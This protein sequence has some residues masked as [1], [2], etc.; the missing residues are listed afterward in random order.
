MLGRVPIRDLRNVMAAIQDHPSED[1]AVGSAR[2]PAGKIEAVLAEFSRRHAGEENPRISLGEL[3][4][5]MQKRAFGLL[6]LML[7]LPCCLPF[8]YGLPQIVALPILLLAGQMALGR[9]TP[10]LPERLRKRSFT[11]SSISNALARSRRY[12]A[13]V[14]WI[15][16]PRLP[17]LTGPAASRITGTLLLIPAASILVPLPLTNTVPGIAIAVVSVGLIERDGLMVVGGLFLGIFWVGALIIGGHAA[18]SAL[19]NLLIG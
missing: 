13:M 7:A 2:G 18:I 19:S 17:G 5:G 9:N 8:V 4:D 14:E 15:C 12:L 1:P 6:L 10:W 11:V 16:H 3:F